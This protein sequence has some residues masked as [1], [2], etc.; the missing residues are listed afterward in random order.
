MLILAVVWSGSEIESVGGFGAAPEPDARLSWAS[1]VPTRDDAAQPELAPAAALFGAPPQQ[2]TRQ[3]PPNDAAPGVQP[4]KTPLGKPTVDDDGAISAA[5]RVRMELSAHAGSRAGSRANSSENVFAAIPPTYDEDKN[6]PQSCPSTFNNIRQPQFSID[7]L[8]QLRSNELVASKLLPTRTS[9]NS[10]MGYVREL[11]LSEAS[12]RKQLVKTKQ[13]TEEELTHSLSKVSELERTMQE[14]E[15]DRELARKKLEEQEQLIRDL[16]AKLKQA[17]AAKARSSA[18]APVDELP[19]IAEEVTAQVETEVKMTDAAVEKVPP[20]EAKSAEETTQAHPI[21]TQPPLAPQ[22]QF[23]AV[24]PTHLEQPSN[25]V[26]AA[27]FGLASPRSPNRPL[28]DPWASGGATPMKNL[29]PVFTIGSTGLDP[30]VASSTAAQSSTTD[31]PRTAAGEY[32]LKSVLMSPRPVQD[33]VEI[34]ER[35]GPSQLVEQ[36]VPSPQQEFAPQYPA[37]IFNVGAMPSPPFPQQQDFVPSNAQSETFG[38]QNQEETPL[39]ESPLLAAPMLPSIGMASVDEKPHEQQGGESVDGEL[40][41]TN[42]SEW[43]G[44]QRWHGTSPSCF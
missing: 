1:S 21:P 3:N 43:T 29:P 15:R 32:E 14:V 30:V 44:K 7:K 28:W 12:L 36:K 10:L 39:M 37:P 33:Q 16:A 17:E 8:R 26:R 11:Q 19:S 13:H 25:I 41:Q 35:G 40:V 5:Q 18:A 4:P 9:V 31:V 20:Q 23:P 38:A 27:Q 22:N 2:D 34:F 42:G 6:G 24:P